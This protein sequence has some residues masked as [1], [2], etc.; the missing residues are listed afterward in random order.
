MLKR[1]GPDVE[2]GTITK[3]EERFLSAA[4]PIFPKGTIAYH[5]EYSKPGS[6]ER[7]SLQVYGSTDGTNTFLLQASTGETFTGDNKEISKRFMIIHVENEAA[8]FK[9]TTSTTG[10]SAYQLFIC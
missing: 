9:R 8:G 3:W 10:S 5:A 7:R 1:Y 6:S 4:S 2:L